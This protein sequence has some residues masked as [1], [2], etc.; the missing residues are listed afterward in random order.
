M[1]QKHLQRKNPGVWEP[2]V[3]VVAM[4]TPSPNRSPKKQ[5]IS[6]S[7]RQIC[8]ILCCQTYFPYSFKTYTK[9][10]A[11]NLSAKIFEFAK[12]IPAV[13]FSGHQGATNISTSCQ[14]RYQ[15]PSLET[16]GF[17]KVGPLPVPQLAIYN[18]MA[19]TSIYL[20]RKVNH[21]ARIS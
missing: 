21:P 8:N 6:L 15:T 14:L 13:F 9:K 5:G 20:Q 4:P 12:T 16:D 17:L 11:R 7:N 3:M 1:I 2:D 10:K 19:I 18:A